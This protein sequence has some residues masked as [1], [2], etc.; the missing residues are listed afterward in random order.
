MPGPVF[1]EK[2]LN[3]LQEEF[4]PAYTACS[5][6]TSKNSYLKGIIKPILNHAEFKN[7]LDP[8]LKTE[9]QWKDGLK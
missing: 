3:V 7:Q 2:Q 1:T 6:N 5:T 8:N 4:L 9:A